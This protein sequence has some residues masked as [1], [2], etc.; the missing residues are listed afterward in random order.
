MKI[1]FL[2]LF[3]LF[4]FLSVQSQAKKGDKATA[5]IVKENGDRQDGQLIIGSITDNEVKITFYHKGS[6]KKNTYKP[7]DIIG[8][9]YQETELDDAG[10][11][12]KRWVHYVSHKV[13]YPPKPFGPKTVFLQKEAEGELTL[14]TYYIEVRNN[15]KQPFR[16]FYYLEDQDGN[17]QKLTE[18]NFATTSRQVFQNYTAL[19]KRI[20]QKSFQYRNLDRMVRDY[21]Y[22]TV[23][24]NDENEYRVA[25]KD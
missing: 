4:T 18:D 20:G 11:R 14:Y 23:S 6:S 16:Y 24:K 17:L 12:V 22:W 9:G 5:Y 21:N 8:Y 13:D 15:P 7:T 10:R 25:M 3:L 1:K 2:S 19:N